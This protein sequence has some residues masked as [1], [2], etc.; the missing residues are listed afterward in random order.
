MIDREEMLRMLPLVRGDLTIREWVRQDV[1]LLAS[2]P[3][4][5]FPSEGFEF[6]FARMGPTER[7]ELFRTRHEKPDTMVLVADH[8]KQPAIG[9]IAPRSID[10]GNGTVGNFGF[11]VR[12]EWCNRGVGTAILRHVTEWSFECGIKRWRLDVAASNA[13]AV[14]CYEKVGFVR[15]GEMWREASDLR[16]IDMSGPRYGFLRPHVRKQ[17]ETFELGFLVMELESEHLRV[18]RRH[19][20]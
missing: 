7:D 12:P 15:T 11:R 1:E 9:Y 8:V 2:W 20:T 10:W 13:R 6:S 18:G 16:E 14:R 5:P 4:Y 3:K 17:G 19:G